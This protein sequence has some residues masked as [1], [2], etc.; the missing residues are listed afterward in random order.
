MTQI[1]VMNQDMK[2]EI[3][4]ASLG[5]INNTRNDMNHEI[6]STK[7]T[8]FTNEVYRTAQLPQKKHITTKNKHQLH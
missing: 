5:N 3:T 6:M 8:T 1:V 7:K 2:H 4:K